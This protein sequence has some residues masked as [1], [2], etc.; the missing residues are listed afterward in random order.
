VIGRRQLLIGAACVTGSGAAWAMTP[1]RRVS[2]LGARRLDRITPRTFGDW[3][4]FD[5]TDLVAPTEPD[6]LASR[7][8]G[9]TVARIYRSRATGQGVMLLVAHG[10]AQTSDLMIHRPEACYPAFGF[11]IAAIQPVQVDLG[12]GVT[13]PAG[14]M[15]ARLSDRAETVLYWTRLGEYFPQTRRQQQLDRLRTALAGEIGDG[16][17][18]RVSQDTPDV[19]RSFEVMKGFAAGLVRAMAPADMAALIGIARARGLR[20]S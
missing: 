17:L 7:I 9:Q 6:S 4:S 2:L 11:S 15:I 5:T 14:T 1:R 16:V 12:H 13:I 10:D 19:Q 8:Y 20:P 3:T 18:F